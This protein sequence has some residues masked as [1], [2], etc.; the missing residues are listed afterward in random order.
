MRFSPRAPSVKA[1]RSIT[2]SL[3][4]PQEHK[5]AFSTPT[6]PRVTLNNPFL[7]AGLSGDVASVGT[8]RATKN[9]GI[10]KLP[11][12]SLNKAAEENDSGQLK[13]ELLTTGIIG[14]LG[15]VAGMASNKI[16][17][18]GLVR[19]TNRNA[20]LL[21]GGLGLIADYAGLQASKHLPTS[22]KPEIN[23]MNK[24]AN[25]LLVKAAELRESTPEL[26]A[27]GLLKKA[28]IEESVARTTV[29]QE[30]MEKAAME[31]LT[32]S[33]I[34]AEDAVRLVKAANI[35][36]AELQGASLVTA[37]ET[38]ADVLEKAAAYIDSQESQINALQGRVE[39]LE[40]AVD[41][42]S[43]PQPALPETFTKMA[44][45]GAFTF[46]DLEALKTVPQE[47]L[48]KMASAFD[49]PWEL[50]K[51]A[52]LSASTGDPLLDFCLG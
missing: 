36:I 8:P 12:T 33:G 16:L 50:G 26:V 46:E 3:H 45:V 17:Q 49:Q 40:H 24:V 23:T 5:V 2:K 7:G 6:K 47:T 52:G 37:E 9:W 48:T 30:S 11:G 25:A 27:I 39:D 42:A 44:S 19:N 15:G 13:H 43:T 21:G 28:G 10:P 22:P 32:Y 51:A 1:T 14:G 18:R 20:F 35:N 38:L 41:V 29:M 4:A 31:S 34:D